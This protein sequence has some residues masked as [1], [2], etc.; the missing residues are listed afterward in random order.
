MTVTSTAVS[1]LPQTPSDELILLPILVPRLQME[2]AKPTTSTPLKSTN[3]KT[4]PLSLELFNHAAADLDQRGE[5]EFQKYK[6][7]LLNC[8][9]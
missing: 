7:F 2:T 5:I 6:K 9:P 1:Q 8:K 3:I 4:G